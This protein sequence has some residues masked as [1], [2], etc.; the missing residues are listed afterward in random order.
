MAAEYVSILESEMD[1]LLQKEL[2]WNKTLP[3]A[4][5]VYEYRTRKNPD[6]IIKV[7]SSITARGVGRKCGGDAIRICAVNTKTN[8]GVF[9]SKRIN[10][11]PGWDIRLKER[12]IEILKQIW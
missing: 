6:I 9:K 4:E 11:V 2:G 10:R 12:V 8:K 5:Y 1:N 7:F 3:H